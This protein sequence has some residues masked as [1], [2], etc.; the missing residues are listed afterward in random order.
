MPCPWSLLALSS[1]AIHGQV[2]FPSHINTKIACIRIFKLQLQKLKPQ[3]WKSHPISTY[4]TFL[5]F[6]RLNKF[7]L[8][9]HYFLICCPQI[10]TLTRSTLNSTSFCLTKYICMNVR[11]GQPLI[12]PGDQFPG[13]LCQESPHCSQLLI[14][15][16]LCFLHSDFKA[17]KSQ[18]YLR[19]CL[20]AN[21]YFSA[22]RCF[23]MFINGAL[24][25]SV[26]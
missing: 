22:F 13:H 10:H 6:F 2:I 18:T 21:I 11:I 17:C 20:L 26:L 16:D 23:I 4:L 12:I 24:M 1:G 15:S 9:S 14:E 5:V 19:C 8:V 7:I 3:H 25:L